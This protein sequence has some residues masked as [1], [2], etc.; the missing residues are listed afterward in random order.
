M[1]ERTYRAM[2]TKLHPARKAPPGCKNEPITLELTLIDGQ[3]HDSPATLNTEL[4]EY[5][6]A[7]ELEITLSPKERHDTVPIEEDAI[8]AH[9]SRVIDYW[10]GKRDNTSSPHIASTANHYVDAY[11]SIYT[12]LFGTT[13]E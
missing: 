3:S 11:Q 9:L 5:L 10:H 8:E 1:Q 4:A 7:E 6:N 13:K 12:S 2:L